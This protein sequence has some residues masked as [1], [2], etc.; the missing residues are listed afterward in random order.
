MLADV[1]VNE[2]AR[3]L[4]PAV[5]GIMFGRGDHPVICGIVALQAGDERDAHAPGEERIF[6]I[7]FL[8]ASPARI[9][10]D[11]DVGRPEIEAFEDVARVRRALP[12]CA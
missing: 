6:A 3:G 4:G 8:A 10:K 5:H 2:V 9:A 7:G 1:H 11:V 12:A